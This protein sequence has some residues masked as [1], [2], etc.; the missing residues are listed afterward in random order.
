[1]ICPHC[2]QDITKK[3]FELTWKGDENT[4]II[5]GYDIADAMRR[6]GIGGGALRALDTWK[7]I[8]EAYE[9]Y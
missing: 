5:E 8:I 4:Q 9:E 3:R 2:K 1:M 6:A 7:E